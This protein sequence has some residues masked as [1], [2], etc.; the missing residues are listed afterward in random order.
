MNEL[1]SQVNKS[2]TIVI[3]GHIRP[4]GDCVGSCLG[5][6]NYILDNYPDKKVDIYLQHFSEDFMFLNGA[7]RIK[8]AYVENITYDLCISL[9]SG[10]LDRHGEFVGYFH[11]AANTYCVDHHI[12]NV[13]FG[14]GYHI[15]PEA[16]STSEAL[17]DLMDS[18]K[19][20]YY[21]A[22]ALYLGIVHDTG[23]FKHSNTTKKAM[24]IAG[25]LISK[26]ARPNYVIDETFY[27]KTYVQN[28][29][30]G[31]ALLESFMLLDGK[32]IVSVL[33][34]EIFDFYKASSMDC[35]GIVDQLRV[36]KGV[37]VAMFIYELSKNEFK[38]SLRSNSIVN[39]STIASS[40]GGGG[41]IRA[42]GFSMSG[43]IYDIINNISDCIYDQL[44]ASGG[45]M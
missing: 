21:C 11:S 34:K 30:L 6:Y 36:T 18:D 16:C 13:G 38:I 22:E 15:D 25:D 10:D 26:G 7:D 4:D 1:F 32:C 42:A 41:H 8:H 35:D 29:L 43:S 3:L 37:E 40:F 14:K 9:D 23:V 44:N 2:N 17:Y 24:C 28:Q 27:K 12:S 5:L 39:V 20:S 19:I 33:K 31:R 45:Q